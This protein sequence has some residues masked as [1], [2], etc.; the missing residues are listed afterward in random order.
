MRGLEVVHIIS[1]LSTLVAHDVALWV[2]DNFS[3]I[4]MQ[5]VIYVN[6]LQLGIYSGRNVGDLPK[7]FAGVPQV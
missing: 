1:Y 3:I 2:V 7:N 5:V 4:I 6:K